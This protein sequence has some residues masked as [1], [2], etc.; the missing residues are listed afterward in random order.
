MNFYFV[1]V[2]SAQVSFLYFSVPF[3]ADEL[4]I[5]IVTILRHFRFI[6]TVNTLKINTIPL[7]NY[8]CNGKSEKREPFKDP[9]SMK[10]IFRHFDDIY[11][12]GHLLYLNGESEKQTNFC[13]T[14]GPADCRT[15]GLSDYSYAPEMNTLIKSLLLVSDVR[16]GMR[17]SVRT[18][19]SG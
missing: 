4:F 7:F 6:T 13:R 11:I 1:A 5:Y 2:L 3:L 14:I 10:K 19:N 16:E 17:L 9:S 15:N 8:N 12:Y 18:D